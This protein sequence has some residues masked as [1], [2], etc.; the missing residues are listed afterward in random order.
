[1][2]AAP[3]GGGAIGTA[4]EPAAR[5]AAAQ[6]AEDA[7]VGRETRADPRE[8]VPPP[9]VTASV[10]PGTAEG[11]EPV[12]AAT[13]VPVALGAITD[14]QGSVLGPTLARAEAGGAGPRPVQVG[15]PRVP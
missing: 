13:R 14:A 15:R 10:T 9:S 1:M 5:T 7:T 12:L 2:A 3:A 4:P 11:V 6:A 8:A